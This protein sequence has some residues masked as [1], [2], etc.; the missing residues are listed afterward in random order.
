M[1]LSALLSTSAMLASL[2]VTGPACAETFGSWGVDLSSRDLSV[3]PGDDFQRYASG[4]WMAATTIPADRP[5]VGAFSDLHDL[6]QEQL[7]KLITEA[8]KGSKYGAL[9][10]SF[11]DEKR[12]EALKL[13]PLKA[14]LLALAAITNKTDFTRFMAGTAGA[15]GMSLVDFDPSAD[16]VD[17]GR[18]VLW[19]SQSGLGLSEREYYFDKQFA[20]QRS[21]YAAYITRTLKA[22]GMPNPRAAAV[23]VMAFE[24]AIAEKKLESC[25]PSRYHKNQ[26]PDEQRGVGQFCTRHR[27]GGLF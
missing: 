18:N 25:R 22:I 6:T 3:K 5:G 8:P 7:Q 26:Q 2:M 19:L 12:V 24:T 27:V 17:P 20:R 15:F 13:K 4:K 1:K 21:A 16:T 23:K 11:M 14:D 9:Y 10:A